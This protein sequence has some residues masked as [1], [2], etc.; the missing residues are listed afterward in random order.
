MRA[1]ASPATFVSQKSVE[2][3]LS[4]SQNSVKPSNFGLSQ[5]S[6][7][8]HAFRRILLNP[9]QK[10]AQGAELSEIRG[11]VSYPKRA[12]ILSKVIQINHYRR[13]INVK[14]TAQNGGRKDIL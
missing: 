5:N 10:S 3:K 14:K 2:Q 8:V 13:K 11:E 6:V 12:E 4:L 9:T 7:E 1:R